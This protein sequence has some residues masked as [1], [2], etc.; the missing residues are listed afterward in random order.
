MTRTRR[1]TKNF[2]L[3]IAMMVAGVFTMSALAFA[4]DPK[5][6]PEE[7]SETPSP[8]QDEESVDETEKK[9]EKK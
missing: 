7:K 3:L 8:S 1:T 4:E 9:E 6:K 5:P 2:A